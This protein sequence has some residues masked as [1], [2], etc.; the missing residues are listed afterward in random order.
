M[1]IAADSGGSKTLL[2]IY[3][4]TSLVEEIHME[5]FG[6]AVDSTEDIP[7]LSQKLSMLSSKYQIEAIAFNLGGRNK[8]QITQILRNTF[9]GIP[10]EVFRE[11]EGNAALALANHYNSECILLAGTGT[12]AIGKHPETGDGIISGGWGCVLGDHGSGYHIGL[13]ALQ[14]AVEQL[15]CT[16]APDM[17]TRRILERNH[18]ILGNKDIS[19]ICQDR[20]AV[21]K[22]LSPL[23]RSHI[24][25]YTR[26][27]AACCAEQDTASLKIMEDA[28]RH[29]AGIVAKAIGKLNLKKANGVLVTGGLLNTRAYWQTSF[30]TTLREQFDVSAFHYIPDGVIRG[31]QLIAAEMAKTKKL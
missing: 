2:H 6:S 14:H 18:G 23:S 8:G 26:L 15:D 27:V 25:A 22:A 30:E 29:M 19:A 9:P 4:D 17:L 13:T 1:I 11:S 21:F 31:T 24:A 10:T 28:G 7:S 5:G 3:D 20:D 12:I 16:T